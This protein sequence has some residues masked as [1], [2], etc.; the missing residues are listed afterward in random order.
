[1]S[2]A[3]E[4]TAERL[5]HFLGIHGEGDAWDFKLTF[6]LADKRM[7]AEL[8]RDVLAF[9]N[10]GGGHLI[11]GVHPETY[12]PVG[13]GER[14]EVDTTKLY[15]ALHRYIGSGV[16]V[17]AAVYERPAD[18]RARRFAIVYIAPAD[19][20]AMPTSIAN[21]PG[22]GG[23]GEC[24][25]R[26][27]DI[28]VRTGGSTRVADRQAIERLLQ[29]VIARVATNTTER[30]RSPPLHNLPAREQ[31][32]VEFVGRSSELAHLWSWFTDPHRRRWMLAG[33][34]GKGKT[35][36]AYEFAT[37]V[38]E[39]VPKGID[40]VVWL[41]AKRR[42][43]IDGVVRT[44]EAPDFVDLESLLDAFLRAIGFTEKLSLPLPDK[45]EYVLELFRELPCLLIADDIDSLDQDA[46]D[47]VEF[48]TVDAPA[49]KSKVLLTSR[50]IPYGLGTSSTQVVGLAG[51]D[52]AA[53]IASRVRL[54]A[55][56][57]AAFGPDVVAAVLNVTDGSP[58]YVEDL[59]RYCAVV[60]V[61]KAI[62]EWRKAGGDA[63]RRYALEREF[64][65]L[66]PVARQIVLA[67]CA[68]GDPVSLPEIQ[69]ATGLPETAV[70][71][72]LPSIQ[73]LFL[74]SKPRLIENVQRFDTNLNTRALVLSLYEGKEALRRI[75]EGLA[76]IR[77]T[78]ETKRSDV[79]AYIRQAS[80]LERLDKLRD[81][82]A[83]LR[84]GLETLPSNADL[85]GQLGVLYARWRPAARVNEA[86]TS[87]ERAAQLKCRRE[88]VYAEWSELEGEE[89]LEWR[90]A[91]AAAEKGLA[92]VGDS[93]RLLFLAGYAH[94]RLG[95]ELRRGLH[96]ER[97]REELDDGHHKLRRALE[98]IE[99][100]PRGS[101][102]NLHRRIFRSLPSSRRR[103]ETRGRSASTRTPGG[104]VFPTIPTSPM[105]GHEGRSCARRVDDACL[106]C[107]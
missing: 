63:A 17:T 68:S 26:P 69:A 3:H 79:T 33:D 95:Q 77:G 76:A 91:A 8:A 24:I 12:E 73:N 6:D 75:Q 41:S 9:A 60:P 13:I 34:G 90:A 19:T 10:S 25:F 92:L 105:V 67:C 81:A 46:E 53:F 83:V 62:A 84:A 11:F 78:S 103:S 43:L 61:A 52:G 23:K 5:A 89:E 50:R 71:N 37:Q 39:A 74:V 7:C 1:M 36:I 22:P 93:A 51:E 97:A 55:L 44:R 96:R 42:E 14:V 35:A 82:E 21:A 31:V 2:A 28:L 15:D 85:I 29:Q 87:F 102:G 30:T 64:D 59:L 101:D 57:T 94:S 16:S 99:Q 20:I 58:L 47:A 27:Q 38:V 4:V 80:A 72:D 106:R 66:S 48:L 107:A 40:S 49:T 32:A 100:Q 98:A 54:H 45:R 70:A 65:M 86:R 104:G 18:G 56:D 88:R